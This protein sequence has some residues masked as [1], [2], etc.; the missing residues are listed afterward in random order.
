MASGPPAQLTAF[1][2]QSH[3]RLV[4]ALTLYCGDRWVAEEVAQEALLRA[5]VAWT[6]LAAHPAPF[7]WLVRVAMNLA[8]SEFRRRAAER[9]ALR[10][11][12]IPAADVPDPA[13]AVAVREALSRIAERPRAVVILR[14]YLR[15]PAADV[16][17]ALGMSEAGVRVAAHRALA[18]LRWQVDVH[19]ALTE[20]TS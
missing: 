12:V 16:G 2:E 20:V 18:D 17:A 14:Y 13:D 6:R 8:R 11:A 7:A 10:R 4:G 9:R 3:E 19:D 5:C 1:C 15:W